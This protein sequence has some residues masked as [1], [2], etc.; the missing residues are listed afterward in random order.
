MGRDYT[1]GGMIFVLTAEYSAISVPTSRL[2]AGTCW[3][4]KVEYE[5]GEREVDASFS[6]R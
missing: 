2:A 5:G 6:V 1:S 4:T 3:P